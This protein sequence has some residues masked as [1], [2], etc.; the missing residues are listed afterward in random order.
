[1]MR[2]GKV[3]MEK[4]CAEHG[5]YSTVIW[6]GY[7]DMDEWRRQA[8]AV[9][10][11]EG[12]DCPNMC[13]LCAQHQSGT[14]CV[15]LEVTRRCNLSCPFC[16]ANGGEGNDRPFSDVVRDL[17]HLV[18]KG[19]TLVQLSG[20]E[21]TVRDDLPDIVRAAKN[22]GCRYVQLNSNGVRLGEDPDYVKRLKDAGLSFVFMQFDGVDDAVYRA[23]PRPGP[24]GNQAKGDRQLR[25]HEYRRNARTHRRAR[26]E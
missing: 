22:A 5:S 12:D 3:Y 2:D 16:F 1:M 23:L 18:V 7:L 10:L 24:D 15:L 9:L 25:R 11:A 6:R 19:Q 17:N 14:C 20:G 26:F 13:G 8:P 21:P 4:T